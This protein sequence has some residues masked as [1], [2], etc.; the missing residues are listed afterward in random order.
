MKQKDIK[1]V[2]F[3]VDGTLTDGRLYIGSQG[4][5]MKAFHVK[6]G[7]GICDILPKHGIKSAIITARNSDI[8][9][10][11]AKELRIDYV[12]Q[13]I[14]NKAE[15]LIALSK[16]CKCNLNQVAYMGDDILDIPCMEL[17]QTT[18]CPFDAVTQ[19]KEKADFI[20]QYRGGDGAVR[21]FIEWLVGDRK[22]DGGR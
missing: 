13:G 21:E 22:M 15:Q 1:L 16:Q 5:I 3:D 18:G 7:C 11:R 8:V 4:E 9:T 2:A 6:D 10:R 19:V 20:S 17:C 12:C 14:R